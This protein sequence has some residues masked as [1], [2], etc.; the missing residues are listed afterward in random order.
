MP[1]HF[2]CNVVLISTFKFK[3]MKK[4]KNKTVSHIKIDLSFKLKKILPFLLVLN[5]Q[6]NLNY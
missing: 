1:N 2:P 3:K 5:L 4:Y 6:I